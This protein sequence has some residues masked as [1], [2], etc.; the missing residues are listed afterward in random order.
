MFAWWRCWEPL[1][2]WRSGTLPEGEQSGWA[3]HCEVYICGIVELANSQQRPAQ[4][5]QGAGVQLES[6]WARLSTLR[7]R[8]R[9]FVLA[10]SVRV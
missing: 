9:C 5:Q 7:V 4:V 2:C 3:S 8:V 6:H 1:A 10:F